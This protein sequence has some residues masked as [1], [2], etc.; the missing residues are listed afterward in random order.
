MVY[1]FC[2]YTSVNKSH[3]TEIIVT[4]VDGWGWEGVT[5]GARVWVWNVWNCR[6]K[7][8]KKDQE[9]AIQVCYLRTQG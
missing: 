3:L 1:T 9:V 4:V 5:Y 6:K 2:C 8:E 7:G